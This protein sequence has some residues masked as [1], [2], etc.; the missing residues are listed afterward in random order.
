MRPAL[1]CGLYEVN[2]VGSQM[3]CPRRARAGNLEFVAL[4]LWVVGEDRVEARSSPLLASLYSDS[5]LAN[6]SMR[7]RWLT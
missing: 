7:T 1:P 2:S 4:P 5:A 6:S 3:V